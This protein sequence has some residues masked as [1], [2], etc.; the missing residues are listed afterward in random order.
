MSQ[1]EDVITKVQKH[2]ETSSALKD[3]QKSLQSKL[4]TLYNKRDNLVSQIEDCQGSGVVLGASMSTQQVFDEKE[5]VFHETRGQV[6]D[7]TEKHERES[8]IKL[9][10]SSVIGVVCMRLGVDGED[11]DLA[12]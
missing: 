2:P 7:L 10:L 9:E 11:Q 5:R 4:L 3:M 6:R 12:D 1:L 8:R